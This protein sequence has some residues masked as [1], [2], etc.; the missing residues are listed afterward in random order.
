VKPPSILLSMV[1]EAA[2]IELWFLAAPQGLI[3]G[4]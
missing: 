1:R 4:A 2:Q 3:I